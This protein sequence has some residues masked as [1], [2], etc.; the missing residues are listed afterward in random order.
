[1]HGP[2]RSNGILSLKLQRHPEKFLVAED[3]E[4]S[5]HY[6]DHRVRHSIKIYF[7]SQNFR[8]RLK[9]SLP[10]GI[11]QDHD[12]ATPGPVLVGG[13]R[14]PQ[15]G[16]NTKNG[17]CFCTRSPTLNALYRVTRPEGVAL[18]QKCSHLRERPGLPLPLQE[19]RSGKVVIVTVRLLLKNNRDF[20]RLAKRRGLEQHMIDHAEH[21]RVRADSQCEGNDREKRESWRFAQH[22]QAKARILQRRI[23]QRVSTHRA[24]FFFDALFASKIHAGL[25]RSFF[26]LHSA[27]HVRLRF[28]LNVKTDFFVQLLIDSVAVED[29]T[30]A[31]RKSPPKPHVYA[32][33]VVRRTC[34]TA[35]VKR[36]QSA[37][38]FSSR[39]RPL[40]LSE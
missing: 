18:T 10:Q 33:Q 1:M 19:I 6:T 17:K 26:R 36:C 2:G 13:E 38:S 5:R 28:V 31:N 25:A 40:R 14:P 34:W 30:D 24:I 22:P 15:R 35:A 9:A 12:I 3:V 20:G 21:C 27:R 39:R 16:R 7:D 4:A 29:C 32:P 37:V 23:H 8:I 11:A